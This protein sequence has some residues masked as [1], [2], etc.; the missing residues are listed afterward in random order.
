M[1]YRS[2]VFACMM[3]AVAAAGLAAQTEAPAPAQSPV[4]AASPSLESA[5]PVPIPK[6]ASDLTIDIVLA[7]AA[8]YVKRYEKDFGGVVAEERYEQD[9]R[10]GGRFDQFGSIHHD[11]GKHRVLRSDLLLVRPEGAD[12]WQQ[13]RDVFE[14]D[15]RTV[16]DRNDRLAK[17]FLDPTTTTAKQIQKIKDE[18]ARY[19]VGAIT[20]NHNIPV[21]ALRI[22]KVENQYR[23]LFNHDE[24]ADAERTDGAWAI[25]YREVEPGTMIRT[26][27]EEDLPVLGRLWIEP[28]TGRVFGTTLRAESKL[29]RSQI[30]VDYAQD[31]TLGILVPRT[32]R[33]AYRQYTDG[34][35]VTAVATYSNFRRFQVKV[36]EQIAPIK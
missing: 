17:L 12:S 4:P 31:A 5:T 8:A 13:F 34:A 1:G 6:P 22:V 21:F 35:T 26:N 20:R 27:G 36:D 3:A 9:S 19:N 2:L 14:V 33:E 24:P 29:L 15:G 10:Q 32:M 30:D 18:S 16:R 28:T 25:D 23:F 11:A 7:R